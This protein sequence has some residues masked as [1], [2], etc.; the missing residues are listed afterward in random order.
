MRLL[1]PRVPAGRF[2]FFALYVL[3][4]ASLVASYFLVLSIRRF[5]ADGSSRILVGREVVDAFIDDTAAFDPWRMAAFL[6]IAFALVSLSVIAVLRRLTDLR[7]N[8]GWAFG[9]VIPFLGFLIMLALLFKAGEQRLISA[10]Y[11]KDP[12]NPNNWVD[13]NHNPGSGIS[14]GGTDLSDQDWDNAA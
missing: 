14:W 13:P 5:D 4:N 10:P 1:N 8:H 7:W 11:G 12:Y 2:E 9:L 6:L 3:F